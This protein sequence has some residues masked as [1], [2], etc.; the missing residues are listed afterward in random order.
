MDS[1]VNEGHTSAQHFI[2]KYCLFP[3][4]VTAAIINVLIFVRAARCT[5]S[6]TTSRC[7]KG[8]TAADNEERYITRSE[9]SEAECKQEEK[10]IKP[11][12]I[13]RFIAKLRRQADD[14]VKNRE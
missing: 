3:C 5:K 6:L 14:E 10:L 8:R 1:S 7:K 4:P 9:K 2:L 12:T 13:S 11:T